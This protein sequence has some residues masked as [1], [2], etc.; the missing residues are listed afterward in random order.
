MTPVSAIP[1]GILLIN[2]I[3]AAAAVIGVFYVIA[4]NLLNEKA[5]H[6]LTVDAFTLRRNHER[7]LAEMSN[8]GNNAAPG[9][10]AASSDDPQ[11]TPAEPEAPAATPDRMAA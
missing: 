9:D 3:L 7:R 2:V 6:T 1:S 8:N 11:A 10:A 5:V 4:I